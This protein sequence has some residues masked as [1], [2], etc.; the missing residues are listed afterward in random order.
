MAKDPAFLFYY[1]DFLVGTDSFTNEET[2][3]YIRCLCHQAHKGNITDKH[4]KKICGKKSIFETV[5]NKFRPDGNGGLINDR[6][7]LEVQKRIDFAESRR[8]NRA[9]KPSTYE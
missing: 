9:G 3:A 5:S 2:G 4:L 6:L 8:R 1:Q 7:Q